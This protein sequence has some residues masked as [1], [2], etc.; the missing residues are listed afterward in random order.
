MVCKRIRKIKIYQKPREQT[1]SRDRPPG[2]SNSSYQTEN[3]KSNFKMS[4]IETK[5]DGG[6][7]R[8]VKS[9]TE[10]KKQMTKELMTWDIG[11]KK[12]SILKHGKPEG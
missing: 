12:I 2:D 1:I 5:N 6:F 4:V 3:F 11:Q 9:T 7:S 8:E 10:W